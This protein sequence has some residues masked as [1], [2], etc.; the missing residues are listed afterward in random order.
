MYTVASIFNCV[1][2]L[3]PQKYLLEIY[4]MAQQLSS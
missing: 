2:D 1:I 4:V 3:G